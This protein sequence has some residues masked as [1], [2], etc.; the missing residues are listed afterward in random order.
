MSSIIFWRK[1]GTIPTVMHGGGCI[2]RWG[3]FSAAGTVRLV[4]IKEKMNGAKCRE[5]LD[6]NLLQ[7]AQDLR[8]RQRLI[9]QQNN[10]PKHTAKIMEEWFWDKSLNVIS[11]AQPESGLEPNQTSLERPENS[12]AAMLPIQP[13]RA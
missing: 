1:P 7:S 5:I 4:R 2:M 10:D 9:F 3:G 11:V 6:E 12:C 13:D 8:L